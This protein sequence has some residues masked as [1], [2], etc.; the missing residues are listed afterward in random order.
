VTK[1][2]RA[3]RLVFKRVSGAAPSRLASRVLRLSRNASRSAG[4][5]T[6]ASPDV[7]GA[8]SRVPLAL[9]G[10]VT[11]RAVGER[12]CVRQAVLGGQRKMFIAVAGIVAVGF[13]FL[14][15]QSRSGHGSAPFVLSALPLALL[16]LITPV[17]LTAVQ[18]VRA[19]QSM[20]AR[21]NPDAKD[22][23]RVALGIARPL[24]LGGVGFLVAM[25]VAA[26]CQ[27]TTRLSLRS[28]ESSADLTRP[29]WGKWLLV[30]SSLLVV[31]VGILTHLTQGI[32]TLIMQAGVQLTPSSGAQGAAAGVDVARFS[33]LISSRLVIAALGGFPLIFIVLGFGVANLFAA[34]VTKTSS[35]LERFSWSVFAMVAI[36]AVWYVVAL[37]ITIRSIERALA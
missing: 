19:F 20:G 33:E 15:R 22:A 28:E 3:A 36:A 6:A 10:I 25:G 18:S 11:A 24:W 14:F 1:D 37:A 32:A 5:L 21:N 9:G 2:F 8:R 7:T 29:T 30:A 23:V 34:R 31:P 16:F 13:W 26:G 17:P 12:Q 35:A 27:V 4:R